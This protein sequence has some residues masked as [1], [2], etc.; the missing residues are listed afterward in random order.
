VKAVVHRALRAG[1]GARQLHRRRLVL[2]EVRHDLIHAPLLQGI[3][4]GEQAARLVDLLRAA[5][6][7]HE[8]APGEALPDGAPCVLD[9]Q[10]P[11]LA[12]RPLHLEGAAREGEGMTRPCH[13]PAGPEVIG[14]A[15][16]DWQEETRGED[17]REGGGEAHGRQPR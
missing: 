2:D 8:G 6:G 1:E 4:H 12:T 5:P 16:N 3:L 15:G 17:S 14:T 7:R 9:A 13:Q 10:G 11:C